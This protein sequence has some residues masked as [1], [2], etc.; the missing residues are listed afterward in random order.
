K[1]KLIAI[2]RAGKA[3]AE[4]IQALLKNL[5]ENPPSALGGS[6]VLTIKDYQ[7]SESKDMASG[8]IEKIDLPQSNVLQFFTEDGS[9]V[10]ARPSGTEPKIK[11]YCSVN[12]PLTS[13]AEYNAVATKLD[14]KL[15]QIL[16]DLGAK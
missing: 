10:S 15:D 16:T 3:G 2:K 5:R 7:S 11:F 8:K 12:E 14:E 4:E 6:K 13:K 1:E 9:I